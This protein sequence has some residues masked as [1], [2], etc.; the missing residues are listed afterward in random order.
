MPNAMKQ[1]VRTHLSAEEQERL[2]QEATA[3]G[4]SISQCIR[5][6]LAEYFAL[7]A[8]V[9]TAFETPGRPGEPR[10]G[11]IQTLLA[12][13]EARLGA[14]LDTCAAAVDG[15]RSAGHVGLSMLDPHASMY[16]VHT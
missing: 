2:G 9:A 3:R 11:L 15:V 5:E 13:T 12:R 16:L 10:T 7:R 1:P 4:I 14:T 8:E 6:S